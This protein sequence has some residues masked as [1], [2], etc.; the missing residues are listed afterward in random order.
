MISR[1]ALTLASIAFL[2]GCATKSEYGIEPDPA[3][4]AAGGDESLGEAEREIER[5]NREALESGEESMFRTERD[6]Y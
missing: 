2:A 4:K 5:E 1:F 3:L 6:E